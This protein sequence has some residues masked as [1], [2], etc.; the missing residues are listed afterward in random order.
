MS[1]AY[2]SQPVMDANPA[3]IPPAPVEHSP[4]KQLVDYLHQV[5]R[6]L[7]RREKLRVLLLWLQATGVCGA[8]LLMLA[9]QI[10]PS[11]VWLPIIA[12]YSLLSLVSLGWMQV[13]VTTDR[14]SDA[15]IAR[16]VG[17]RL[18]DLRS[19]LLSAVELE[20]DIGQGPERAL[21]DELIR[22]TV[23]AL[24]TVKPVLLVDEWPVRQAAAT[25]L[26]LL[27]FGL[28]AT[29]IGI[30]PIAKGLHT[31]LT[32]SPPEPVTIATLSLKYYILL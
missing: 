18:P 29:G 30:L 27:F 1:Q 15:A 31:L 17:D 16:Y 12:G 21:V 7:L 5:R 2:E 20:Q 9:A 32:I 6:R 13:R 23:A 10:G 28:F 14:T 25:G 8:V 24:A 26:M 22:R 3:V 4:S 11:W 19:E